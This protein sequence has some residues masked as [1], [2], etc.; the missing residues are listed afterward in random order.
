[1]TDLRQDCGVVK[2][3][4]NAAGHYTLSLKGTATLTREAHAKSCENW[5][6]YLHRLHAGN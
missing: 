1:M 6:M 4:R 5:Y 3:R 2:R